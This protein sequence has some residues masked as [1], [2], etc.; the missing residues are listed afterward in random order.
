MKQ[1]KTKKMILCAFF[2]ALTAV[3]A[4]ISLPLPF[5]PVPIN[6]ALLAVY[7]TGAL[8][9]PKNGAL[10]QVVY[11]FI[12][13]VGIPVFSNFTAGPSILAGPTGGYLI[14]YVVAAWLSGL[15]ASGKEVSFVRRCAGFFIAMLSC[16][17]LGTLWFVVLTKTGLLAALSLCVFPF[18]PGDA[19]KILAAALLTKKLAPILARI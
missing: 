2:S 6:L 4:M 10:S 16:Y 15:L 3:G 19:L 5:S 8:L 1:T 11:L 9:G 13:L 12:G 14:G 18:L 17:T 7:L